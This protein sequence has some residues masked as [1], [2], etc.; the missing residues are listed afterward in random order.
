M[1]RY[2]LLLSLVLI[3]GL[4]CLLQAQECKTNSCCEVDDCF[5]PC[6]GGW[7]E[8]PYLL[9]DWG[10]SRS[11]LAEQGIT[12]DASVTQ[13][14]QGVTSGGRRQEFEYSGHGEYILNTDFGK[15]GIQD[16]LF[17]KIRAEHRFGT[18]ARSRP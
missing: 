6:D 18:P 16:G 17:M 11:S 14:Y 1:T 3:W 2:R 7:C 9:G 4:P 15:L 10:G 12:L 13:Y 8:S 5:A